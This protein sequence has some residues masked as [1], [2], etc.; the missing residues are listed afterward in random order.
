MAKYKFDEYVFSYDWKEPAKI[1]SYKEDLIEPAPKDPEYN[2]FVKEIHHLKTDKC[3][4]QLNDI[5]TYGQVFHIP[6]YFYHQGKRIIDTRYVISPYVSFEHVET[7]WNILNNTLWH[8]KFMMK[9]KKAREIY[10]FRR[11]IPPHWF[12]AKDKI[13]AGVIIETIV[14][15]PPNASDISIKIVEYLI[16]GTIGETLLDTTAIIGIRVK[17]TYFGGDVRLWSTTS[18]L[19]LASLEERIHKMIMQIICQTKSSNFKYEI[20]HKVMEQRY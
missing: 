16:L 14:Y 13:N 18:E 6:Q 8:P 17:P 1:A 15:F 2:P 9:S 3:S 20:V 10:F 19:A 11:D 5:W 4:H 12:E 7:M